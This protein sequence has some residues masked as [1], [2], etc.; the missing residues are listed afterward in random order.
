MK[1]RSM[2]TCIMSSLPRC[3]FRCS[4][5]RYVTL[6]SFFSLFFFQ[7]LLFNCNSFTL[8]ANKYLLTYLLTTKIATTT[9]AHLVSTLWIF[10]LCQEIFHQH[11]STVSMHLSSFTMPAVAHTSGPLWQDFCCRATKLIVCVTH[12]RNS[13]AD[14]LIW[15]HKTR[16]MSSKCLLIPSVRWSL[17]CMDLSM[18]KLIKLAKISGAM[19][20]ANHAYPIW[21]TWWLHRLAT[22]APFIGCVI[23][24][25]STF[26]FHLDLLNCLQEFRLSYF[27]LLAICLLL[28]YF[29]SAAVWHCFGFKTH[30]MPI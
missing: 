27:R 14:T 3:I 5:F 19:H 7:T 15:L 29:V 10:L 2:Q 4:V 6:V 25:P 16:T 11:Q 30:E 26:T 9:V 13:M 12:L 1:I 18:P 22:D 24:W 17:F 21:S 28:V 20:E 23:N 8:V